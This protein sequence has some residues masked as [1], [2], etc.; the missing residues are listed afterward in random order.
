[1]WKNYEKEY[2]ESNFGCCYRYGCGTTFLNSK[3]SEALSD[4]AMVNVEALAD[5]A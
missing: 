4:I 1:M 3:Q 2:F 5:Y